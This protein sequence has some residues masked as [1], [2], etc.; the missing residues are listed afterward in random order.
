[1]VIL[2]QPLKYWDYGHK[3]PSLAYSS[4]RKPCANIPLLKHR[5]AQK[6]FILAMF[7]PF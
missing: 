2:Y 7:K 6:P 3:P 1:M 4:E 5:S